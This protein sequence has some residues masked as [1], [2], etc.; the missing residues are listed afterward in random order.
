MA[1]LNGKVW[2][3]TRAAFLAWAL[4][5]VLSPAAAGPLK[6]TDDTPVVPA[7][8]AVTLRIDDSHAL[9]LEQVLAQPQLFTPPP[10]TYAT[11]GVRKEA[12][13]LCIPVERSAQ[14]SP[15]WV[16]DIDYA[17]LNRIDAYVLVDGRL[18][19]HTVL[20]NQQPFSA[21]PLASRSHA[22]AFDLPPGA[23]V[24]L[25]LRVQTTGAMILPITLNTPRAFHAIALNEQMLQGVLAGLGVCLLVYSLVRWASL[26]ET[27][28]LKYALLISGSLL[29]SLFQFGV[30]AQYLWR[31][32]IWL[33]RH[34]GG[35][36]SMMALT[37]SFLFIEHV[38]A[39]A[40]AGRTDSAV[41]RFA[42]RR[43]SRLMKG[44]AAC[45]V[46]LAVVHALDIIDTRAVSAIVSVLGPLPAL[47]GLPGALSRARQRDPVG[48]CFLFAWAVYAVAV[49]VLIGVIN[50]RLP[51]TFWT[52]HSFQ[53]GATLDMLFYMQVLSLGNKA[54][55]T[56]ARHATHERDMMRSLAH[57]DPLTGLINR[58]GLTTELKTA[59]SR[60]TPQRLVALYVLDLDGFKPVND[61]HGHDVGDEL[62]IAVAKRLQANV[63][64]GDVVARPGGDEFV[65]MSSGLATPAQADALAHK[66]LDAIKAPFQIGPHTCHVSLTIGYALAPLDGTDA[67]ALLKQADGAM[68]AGKQAGKGCA[69]R[70]PPP[71]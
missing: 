60:S 47:L 20:G 53:F 71:T 68:Y 39:R 11:L 49:A 66:L 40:P 26:R 4:W 70:S 30:G 34:A 48:W 19:G 27:L 69:R 13:W 25:L 1:H 46:V 36:F 55:H 56:T 16:L 14:A 37:G 6:L 24:E 12:V 58:R 28:S 15:R 63:R 43:F 50:G 3:L 65:V 17:A 54:A 67:A 32:A 52:L 22:M 42:G 45:T 33:E 10:S 59:L 29:F 61:Q 57:S 8:A 51:V 9:T 38:L 23:G 21:R 5:L 35:L 64:S 7:W 18:I 41:P 62:L 2:G 31:D 44:G